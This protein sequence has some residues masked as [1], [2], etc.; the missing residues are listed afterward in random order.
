MSWMQTNGASG[1]W[2]EMLQGVSILATAGTQR[3]VQG[4]YRCSDQGDAGL[5]SLTS[6]V[7]YSRRAIRPFWPSSMSMNCVLYT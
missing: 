5:Y 3:Q 1:K 4:S 7:E 6:C 2:L